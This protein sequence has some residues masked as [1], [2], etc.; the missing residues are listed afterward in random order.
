MEDSERGREELLEENER[1][2]LEVSWLKTELEDK[3][4]NIPSCPLLWRGCTKMPSGIVRPH[5]VVK[6]TKVY[7]GGG[8]TGRMESTRTVFE[9]ETL[10]NSWSKLPIAPYY[11]FGLALVDGKVVVIGG[12]DV[13]STLASDRLAS[14]DDNSKKWCHLLPHMPSKR[15]AVSAAST[16]THL[17]V[18]GGIGV[19][20]QNYLT[21]VEV[22][23]IP[24]KVWAKAAP[25][26]TPV[27]FMSMTICQ[28]LGRIYLLGG[29][30]NHGAIRSVFSCLLKELIASC[31]SEEKSSSGLKEEDGS[32][33]DAAGDCI[34]EVIAECPYFRSGCIAVNGKLVICSGLT[35]SDETSSTI[36]CFDPMTKV[37][38]VLGEMPAARSSC[39]LA[40]IS[41]DQLMVA[42]GYV[43]P[44]NWMRSLTQD[45]MA[46]VNFAVP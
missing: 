26:S 39:S 45:V 3:T 10:A 36:H 4:F 14:F 11:T 38:S 34:W 41:N 29:L 16:S 35:S 30:T 8:N 37:W 46:T 9:Y 19:D 32:S 40:L 12:I 42:G 33:V 20:S 31:T 1:L 21:T 15:C 27:T 17:V 23:D 44:Q 7:V 13:I 2:S 6:G 22:L 43:Q 18:I 25:L 5:I 24:M 28:D